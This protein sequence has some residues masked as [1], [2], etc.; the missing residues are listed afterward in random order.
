MA[1]IEIE[2][3]KECLG[4]AVD[5]AAAKWGK[6]EGWVFE[7]QRISFEAM[8]DGTDAAARALLADGVEEGD[9]VALWMPNRVEFAFVQ[10]ACAKIGAIAVS[11][12]TRFR[13]FE[14][15]H[16][17]REC[18]ASVLIMVE[19][20][21]KHDYVALLDE[22]GAKLEQPAS[23]EFPRLRTVVSVTQTPNPRLLAWEDFIARGSAMPMEKVAE[24]ASRRRTDEPIL[25]QYTSG[26]TAAPK[27]ALLNHGY[28]L[29]VGNELFANMGVGEG[30]PV[31]N[32]QPFYHIGGS[33]GALPTPLTLGC[34]M[35]IPE[36]Y[37]AERVM[38]LIEQERCIARTGFAAMYIMEMNHPSFGRYDLSSVR[39]GWCSG[40][41]EMLEKVR[42]EMGIEGLM[43]TYS[44]TEVGGTASHYTD[45]WE[46][47]STS[48]GPPLKGTE[49]RI[50]DPETGSEM[51]RGEQ[52]EIVM[53]GWWKMNGY[54]KQP[55]QTAKAID[56]DGW[57]HT[58]DR[59]FVD[60]AGCLHFVGR[61]KDMLKV[62]G[63]NVSAEE[64]EG[65]LLSH[66]AIKQVA[67][68]GAPDPRLDEVPMAIVELREGA[69]LTAE[70]L[71]GYCSSRMANFRVP[72]HVRFVTD[73]P[74]TGSGKIMKPKLREIF[75][76]EFSQ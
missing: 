39:A 41:K 57:V 6:A 22:I 53:R 56:G 54:L 71:V 72:R 4:E 21:L 14:V 8:R 43:L 31:L 47:R 23:G 17:L 25:I 19:R 29:N 33:C 65:F 40:T 11:I 24:R 38:Q 70:E 18:E 62:G 44:S 20:F 49:L 48:A 61:Y 34:R 75:L 60:E 69:A 1:A 5:R 15:A 26:T 30:D 45:P 46:Q 50:I 52:G 58:G 16:M 13:D 63:E 37:D 66:P 27:G 2:L 12:N 68:I 64:V 7:G 59:G 32:T 36:F 55:E 74:M 28:V 35:V 51:P 42:A 9:V 73:W 10:F 67:I 3:H 76:P